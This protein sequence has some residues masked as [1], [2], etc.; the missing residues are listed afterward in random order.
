MTHNRKNQSILSAKNRRYFLP[1]KRF[2]SVREQRWTSR[3][4]LCVSDVCSYNGS[5]N[6]VF[7]LY[8]VQWIKQISSSLHRWL[9]ITSRPPITT[10]GFVVGK[11]ADKKNKI[12]SIRI[13]CR[14]TENRP[15]QATFV[16]RFWR[17]SVI[18]LRSQRKFTSSPMITRTE[19][20]YLLEH[21]APTE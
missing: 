18:G 8:E 16:S 2:L 9:F 7:A 5:F 10:P 3:S 11:S 20:G 19:N 4:L 14:P 15:L 1:P 12:F 21:G 13:D 17:S 6:N